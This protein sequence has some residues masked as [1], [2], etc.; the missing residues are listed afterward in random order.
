MGVNV[1]NEATLA[2]QT[3]HRLS[4]RAGKY[5]TQR[6]HFS[7]LDS[8]L[9]AQ[10]HVNG[11]V[12][13][14]V[15]SAT[16]PHFGQPAQASSLPHHR[17]QCLGCARCLGSQWTVLA[18]TVTSQA[19]ATCPVEEFVTAAGI[20]QH[21]DL[22]RHMGHQP[23]QDNCRPLLPPHLSHAALHTN[24]TPPT[25]ADY[26][27]GH[28]SQLGHGVAIDKNNFPFCCCVDCGGGH[29]NPANQNARLSVTLQWPH[30]G[31]ANL[32]A[33]HHYPTHGNLLGSC[34]TGDCYPGAANVAWQRQAD[35]TSPQVQ[36]PHIS[37]SKIPA[38]AKAVSRNAEMQRQQAMNRY[39]SPGGG[40]HDNGHP[41]ALP[42]RTPVPQHLCQQPCH[43]F[44]RPFPQDSS[45]ERCDALRSNA[46]ANQLYQLA[47][48][49]VWNPTD[50][51]FAVHQ[52]LE[53][54]SFCIPNVLD[55]PKHQQRSY[56]EY[57]QTVSETSTALALTPSGASTPTGMFRHPHPPS[58]QLQGGLVD[59]RS[60]HSK[61][62]Y[63]PFHQHAHRQTPGHTVCAEY[64]NGS[65]T[66]PNCNHVTS[67]TD[68]KEMV[69]G[70]G[71][72]PTGIE[73]FME[74]ISSLSAEHFMYGGSLAGQLDSQTSVAGRPRLAGSGRRV[75]DPMLGMSNMVVNDMNSMLTQLAEEN[76][77]LAMQSLG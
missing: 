13:P 62:V 2:S 53:Q 33:P 65:Q 4:P 70:S 58:F 37:Q 8:N 19:A 64:A 36:V 73:S 41:P 45:A 67:T 3:P 47:Y 77:Y 60:P 18:E 43:Q 59:Q 9:H 75:H 72:E 24:P 29:H 71:A 57:S 74:N 38:N 49:P 27:I 69:P 30:Q 40:F 26:G 32:T 14:T 76:K 10:S 50:S 55:L 12:R 17:T 20:H 21:N 22:H 56:P 7:P 68:L 63:Q 46:C 5:S 28:S 51:H 16:R 23:C 6:R 34:N 11:G 52:N 48:R 42:N 44:Q 1:F 61:H 25:V 54:K 35:S 39:C 31:V 15:N 66:S